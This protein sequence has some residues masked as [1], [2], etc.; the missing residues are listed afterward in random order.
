MCCWCWLHA[1]LNCCVKCQTALLA[2]KFSSWKI[3]KEEA[4]F[5]L[6]L[7]ELFQLPAFTLLL[8]L[9][10]CFF[11]VSVGNQ[12][13]IR[14]RRSFISCLVSA[15][16]AHH[17]CHHRYY[18]Q[19]WCSMRLLGFNW[20]LRYTRL[21]SFAGLVIWLS[22]CENVCLC[23]MSS[24]WSCNKVSLLKTEQTLAIWLLWHRGELQANAWLTHRIIQDLYREMLF[25][26][27]DS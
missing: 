13:A 19:Q 21:A 25:S 12:W 9:F 24:R 16:Q 26:I 27:S 7:S 22:L 23:V 2:S 6:S 1:S 11:F 4:Y 18:E 14:G 17:H 10:S 5:K 20:L 8:S 3:K 15:E